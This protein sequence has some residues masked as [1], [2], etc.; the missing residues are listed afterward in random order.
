MCY[1]KDALNKEE[2]ANKVKN[3]GNTILKLTQKGKAI[4]FNKHFHDRNLNI[5]KTCEGIR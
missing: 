3:Y 5:F 4:H 1:A 2:R